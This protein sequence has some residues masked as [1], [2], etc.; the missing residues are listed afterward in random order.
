MS[1]RN[2]KA[3]YGL[4][5]RILHWGMALAIFGLFALGYWMR[6]LTYGSP[7]YQ[8]APDLHQNLGMVVLGLMVFRLFWKLINTDPDTSELTKVEHLGSVLVH[9]AFYVMLFVLMIAGY[10]ILTLNGRSFSFFGLIDIP[11]IYSQKG[12]EKLAGQLHWILAY[13]TM[14]LAV[15][16]GGAAIWHHYVKKDRVMLRM[17]KDPNKL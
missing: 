6:T 12:L 17:L 16:H 14:A 9:W 15:L 11:S 4:V 10:F 3:G 1:Y 5:A 8:S 2:T 13:L 7:Y